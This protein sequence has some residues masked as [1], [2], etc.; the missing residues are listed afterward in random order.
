M[1][2]NLIQL[3]YT[4]TKF[5]SELF[6]HYIV[7]DLFFTFLSFQGLTVIIWL[8]AL[9]LFISWEEYK[10]HKFILYFL[11]SFGI[12]SFFVNIIYK[13]IIMRSRPWVFWSLPQTV[14]PADYSFPSGH[15]AGAFAG[16][17]IFAHF[18]KKRRYWYY[19]L[20]GLISFSRIYLYCH[21]MLD[22]LAGA[23]IGYTFGRILLI[24]D[25]KWRKK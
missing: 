23:L 2:E 17:V 18:D 12:T 21:F 4:V 14:C 15:A 9:F 16:A 19:L 13:N 3:D 8:I 24:A 22:V 10:H 20:A 11:L 25:K 6:P 5:V 7:F 1:V